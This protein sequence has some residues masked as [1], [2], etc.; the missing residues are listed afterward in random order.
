MHVEL[1]VT[2]RVVL[3][4]AGVGVSPRRRCSYP[5]RTRAPTGLVEVRPGTLRALGDLF[6]L[7]SQPLG[8]RRL[9]GF[10]A[11]PGRAVEAFLDGR[12]WLSD[13]RAIPLRRHA[14]IVLELGEHVVPHARYVFPPGL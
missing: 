11:P 10:H 2:R 13:P 12:R 5:L 4:P 8:S 1:I 9:A 14:V 7:W 3:L 6:S